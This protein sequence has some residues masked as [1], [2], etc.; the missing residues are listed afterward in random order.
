MRS[1][2]MSRERWVDRSCGGF[3]V[4]ISRNLGYRIAFPICTRTEVIRSSWNLSVLRYVSHKGLRGSSCLELSV[5][6][7]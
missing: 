4:I 5:G 7:C 1:L 3:L 2:G 6:C